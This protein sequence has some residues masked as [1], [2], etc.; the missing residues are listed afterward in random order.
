MSFLLS[1]AGISLLPAASAIG[2]VRQ[3][4]NYALTATVTASGEDAKPFTGKRQWMEIQ[5]ST[6]RW[7]SAKRIIVGKQSTLA[8]TGL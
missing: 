5:T 8:E 2:T 4:L 7:A 1:G 6:S 3:L